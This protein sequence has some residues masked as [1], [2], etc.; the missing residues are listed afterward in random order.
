M[1][2]KD[3]LTG[4]LEKFHE[5]PFTDKKVACRRQ[6]MQRVI[7]MESVKQKRIQKHEIMSQLC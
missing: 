2:S 6:A 1:Y 3:M 4:V 7:L 5:I